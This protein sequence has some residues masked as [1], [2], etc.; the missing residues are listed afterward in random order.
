MSFTVDTMRPRNLLIL[1]VLWLFTLLTV[2]SYFDWTSIILLA[3]MF[4][5]TYST[6]RRE[7][8]EDYP[9]EPASDEPGDAGDE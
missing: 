6:V 4:L 2:A 3:I 9:A 5:I 7:M 1:A 8:S